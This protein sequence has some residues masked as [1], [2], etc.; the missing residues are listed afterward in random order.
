MVPAEIMG[1]IWWH[2]LNSLNGVI[3]GIISW[4]ITGVIMGD[5]RSLDCGSYGDIILYQTPGSAK[6]WRPAAS[7][8]GLLLCFCNL[9][10]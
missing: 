7:G 2:S 1:S 9:R 10:S 5:A 8:K 3:W 6:A 4:S